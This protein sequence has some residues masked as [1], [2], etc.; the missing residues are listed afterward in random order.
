M[1]AEPTAE[2]PDP[3]VTAPKTGTRRQNGAKVTSDESG[4]GSSCTAAFNETQGACGIIDITAS[5]SQLVTQVSTGISE[6]DMKKA[7]QASRLLNGA[8][9]GA[10]AFFGFRCGRAAE[11]CKTQCDGEID[12]LKKEIARKKREIDEAEAANPQASLRSLGNQLDELKTELGKAESNL[13]TCAG[14]KTKSYQAY[15]QAGQNAIGLMNSQACVTALRETECKTLADLQTKPECKFQLCSPGGQFAGT[16]ECSNYTNIDCNASANF[17]LPYCICQKNPQDPSCPGNIAG[18]PTGGPG[19]GP[20]GGLATDP[21]G[22]HGYQLLYSLWGEPTGTNPAVSGRRPGRHQ[23]SIRPVV[24]PVVT[25]G[26]LT[27][28]TYA[29]DPRHRTHRHRR[30]HGRLR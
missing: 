21:V 4:G 28:P 1:P 29:P 20:G 7:C 27:W 11:T 13:G 10:N 15:F 23:A 22:H 8:G 6:G 2:S 18:D 14:D 16:T 12:R 5:V 24:P 9:A 19:G 3:G 17:G 26:P 25:A 30:R